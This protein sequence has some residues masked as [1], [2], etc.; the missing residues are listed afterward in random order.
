MASAAPR[1]AVGCVPEPEIRGADVSGTGFPSAGSGWKM[2][3]S[4]RCLGADNHSL[5][6]KQLTVPQRLSMAERIPKFL[7]YSALLVLNRIQLQDIFIA[8]LFHFAVHTTIAS[9]QS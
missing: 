6:V 2:T 8:L 3:S 5:S 1:A 7:L 4:E 9:C